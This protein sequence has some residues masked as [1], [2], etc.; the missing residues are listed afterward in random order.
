MRLGDGLVGN[1]SRSGGNDVKQALDEIY[2]NRKIDLSKTPSTVKISK[3]K[4][5]MDEQLTD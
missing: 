4:T 2:W 5:K 3:N 1:M